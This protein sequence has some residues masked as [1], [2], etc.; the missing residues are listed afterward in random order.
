[1]EIIIA[2]VIAGVLLAVALLKVLWVVVSRA[3]DNLLSWAIYN[4][5]NEEAVRRWREEKE[6]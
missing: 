2:G 3:V 5:G 6:I 4:F 1:M